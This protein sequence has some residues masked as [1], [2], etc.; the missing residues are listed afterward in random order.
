MLHKKHIVLIFLFFFFIVD[1]IYFQ[2]FIIVVNDNDKYNYTDNNDDNNKKEIYKKNIQY[3]N[4]TKKKS[5][6]DSLESLY[7]LE[8]IDRIPDS[9]VQSFCSTSWRYPS[10]HSG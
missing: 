3:T 8:N 6:Y 9:K 10:K 1:Y 7:S 5:Y 2:Y 4:L